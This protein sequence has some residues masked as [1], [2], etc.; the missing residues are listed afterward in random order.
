MRDVVEI[1]A[2][3]MGY[4]DDRYLVTYHPLLHKVYFPIYCEFHNKKYVEVCFNFDN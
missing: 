4:R 1:P 2:P 3:E